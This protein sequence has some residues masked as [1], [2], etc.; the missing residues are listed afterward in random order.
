VKKGLFG[1]LLL[2][3]FALTPFS[4]GS[5]CDTKGTTTTITVRSTT[6]AVEV[7]TATVDVTTTEVITDTVHVTTTASQ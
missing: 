4:L 1:F 6:T 2:L 7:I 5:S 3:I